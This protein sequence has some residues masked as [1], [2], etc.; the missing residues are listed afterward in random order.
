MDKKKH[1]QHGHDAL[2]RE[3]KIATESIMVCWKCRSIM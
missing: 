3:A 2:K 1:V